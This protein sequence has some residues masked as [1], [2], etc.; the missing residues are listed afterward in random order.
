MPSSLLKSVSQQI[1]S[2]VKLLFDAVAD[3]SR[4]MLGSRALDLAILSRDLEL[5]KNSPSE[6]CTIYL[7]CHRRSNRRRLYDWRHWIRYLGGDTRGSGDRERASRV[8]QNFSVARH[9]KRLRPN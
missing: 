2:V 4:L 1:R 3:A 6:K 7:G 9:S 8:R 5:V